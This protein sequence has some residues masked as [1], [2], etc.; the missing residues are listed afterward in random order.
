[1][2]KGLLKDCAGQ[3]KTNTKTPTHEKGRHNTALRA[4]SSQQAASMAAMQTPTK[5]DVELTPTGV[6]A[7]NQRANDSIFYSPGFARPRKVPLD[8]ARR[9]LMRMGLDGKVL[10]WEEVHEMLNMAKAAL[11]AKTVAIEVRA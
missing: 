10:A 2:E 6:D 9:I 1:M 8:A 5:E 7:L 11:D 4:C 3:G